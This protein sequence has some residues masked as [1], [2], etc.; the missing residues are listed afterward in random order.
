M[1]YWIFGLLTKAAPQMIGKET[2]DSVKRLIIG[3]DDAR[4]IVTSIGKD[5]MKLK[6]LLVPSGIG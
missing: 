4:G 1:Q 6:E 3:F 5:W 2:Q